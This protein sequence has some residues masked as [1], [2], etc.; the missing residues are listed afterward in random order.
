MIVLRGIGSAGGVAG[1]I[2]RTSIRAVLLSWIAYPRSRLPRTLASLAALSP[3]A[4]SP[5]ALSHLSRSLDALSRIRHQATY[6]VGLSLSRA[7]LGV[8]ERRSQMLRKD[9]DRFPQAALTFATLPARCTP[10][11]L[12]PGAYVSVCVDS[13]KHS[14]DTRFARAHATADAEEKGRACGC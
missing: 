11:S 4:L 9:V 7:P 13:T 1:A 10:R 6:R 2:P 3:P 14:V 12:T 8:G 5:P